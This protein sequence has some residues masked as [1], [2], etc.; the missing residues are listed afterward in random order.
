MHAG[1]GGHMQ[2][3]PRFQGV[4]YAGNNKWHAQVRL[5]SL[6]APYHEPSSS[7]YASSCLLRCALLFRSL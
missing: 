2:A 6:D 7:A 4:R 5:P 3:S 1:A